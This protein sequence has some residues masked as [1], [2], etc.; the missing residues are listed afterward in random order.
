MQH[1]NT[2]KKVGDLHVIQPHPR[3]SP[4]SQLFN[5]CARDELSVIHII[6]TLLQTEAI[7][8]DTFIDK[9]PLELTLSSRCMN[10][11]S[12]EKA[13]PETML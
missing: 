2:R 7:C 5:V 3:P 10:L 8:P 4:Y 12:A 13:E 9:Y 11:C 6:K 1:T